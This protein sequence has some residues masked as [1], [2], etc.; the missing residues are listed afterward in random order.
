MSSLNMGVSLLINGVR[1][2]LAPIGMEDDN[3]VFNAGVGCMLTD[4]TWDL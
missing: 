4:C 2:F 3:P 1:I